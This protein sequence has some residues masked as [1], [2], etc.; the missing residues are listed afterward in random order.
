MFTSVDLNE[1]EFMEAWALSGI[2]TKK[3]FLEEVIRVYLRLHKQSEVRSLRGKLAWNVEP[4][5][6]K[7]GADPR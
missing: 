4:S 1:E 7:R 5:K 3:A 2:K 6:G